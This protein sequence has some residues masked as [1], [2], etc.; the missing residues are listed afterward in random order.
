MSLRAPI[1]LPSIMG[2]TLTSRALN[3]QLK[4]A[5]YPVIRDMTQDVLKDLEQVF[6]QPRNKSTWAETLCVTV[7]LCMCIEELQVAIDARFIAFATEDPS[8]RLSGI[9]ILRGLETH[10]FEQIVLMFHS[11]YRTGQS[12][13]DKKRD[14]GFNPIRN[15]LLIDAKN[16]ITQPMVDLVHEFRQIM[17]DHGKYLS[18]AR[19]HKANPYREGHRGE[20]KKRII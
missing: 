4:Q 18:S 1:M 6:R 12:S 7:I 3:L 16:G 20:S 13:L 5:M 14:F 15:S 8:L 11:V 9:K 2:P 19:R 10:A 17:K